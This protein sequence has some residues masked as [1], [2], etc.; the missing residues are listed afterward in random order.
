MDLGPFRAEYPWD[1]HWF[2][3]GGVAMHYLDEGEGETVVLVHGNPT[4]SFYWRRVV[5]ELSTDHR[6]VVPDHIGMG[7]SD[8]P[9]DADYAYTLQSRVDDLEALLDHLGLTERITLVLHDW[10]GMIGL[11][12]AQRHPD[13]VARLVLMNTAGFFLPAEGRLPWPLWLI[14]NLPFAL[15][16]RGLNAFVV[17][18]LHT[19]S[20][21]PGRMT[22]PIKAGYAAP[23]D[24]WNNR[25]AVHRF[26]QDIP[27]A[28]G[29]PSF[30][31]VDEVT[32]NLEQWRDRPVQIFWG[33][34]DFVFDRHFLAEWRRRLPGAEFHTF[35]DC[36]HYVLEDAHEEILPRL[37][38]FLAAHPLDPRP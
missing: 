26:V 19:C 24:S 22:P 6:C 38:A 4:W 20:T 13:R 1:S 30:D 35:A 21:R 7:L 31:L 16:V 25:I 28:A 5:E 17:G 2:D 27:L 11:A 10:G 36:G 15:P 9:S 33:E 14:K 29:H 12:F 18:A 32:R 23:Y 3:R 37:R 34:R 8:K